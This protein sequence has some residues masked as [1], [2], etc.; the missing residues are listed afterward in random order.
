MPSD[1][2]TIKTR[3]DARVLFATFDSPPINLIGP[4]LVR[5][6]ISLL[7]SLELTRT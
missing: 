1:F 3:R 2:P 5:D 4:Q 7:D 6:L